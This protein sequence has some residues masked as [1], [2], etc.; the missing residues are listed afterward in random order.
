MDPNSGKKDMFNKLSKELALKKLHEEQFSRRT[1]SFYRYVIID[2]PIELR[3]SLYKDWKDLSAVSY[4]HLTLPTIY[5][6]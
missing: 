3:D 4:T 2:N 1:I 6:V 5:S